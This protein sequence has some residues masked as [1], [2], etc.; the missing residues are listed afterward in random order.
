MQHISIL[1]SNSC[2]THPHQVQRFASIE[3]SLRL[4][5]TSTTIRSRLVSP[6]GSQGGKHSLSA[7]INTSLFLAFT[8]ALLISSTHAQVTCDSGTFLRDDKCIPCAPGTFQFFSIQRRTSCTKCRAGTF[9]NFPGAEHQTDC[10]I[11]AQNYFARPGATSCKPC[12]PGTISGVASGRCFPLCP[13]GSERSTNKCTPCNP[14]FYNDGTLRI[15]K[16]CPS[17]TTTLVKGQSQCT[18]CPPGTHRDVSRTKSYNGLAFKCAPCP[19]ASFSNKAGAVQCSLCPVGTVSKPNRRGCKSCPPGT[20]RRIISKTKCDKCPKGTN[21]KGKKPAGCLHPKRGCP[22]HTYLHPSGDCRGCMPGTRLDV[23]R[24]R[25]VK[26]RKNEVSNGGD[27]K[28]CKVCPNNTVPE[29]NRSIFEA[30]RCTC[31]PGWHPKPLGD[32]RG[33]LCKPCKAGEEVDQYYSTNV[34][35]FYGYFFRSLYFSEAS[36]LGCGR[37]HFTARPGTDKCSACPSGLYNPFYEGTS[38]LKCPKGSRANPTDSTWFPKVGQ[39]ECVDLK[40]SCPFGSERLDN[41]IC[42]RK[43]CPGHLFPRGRT[44][45]SCDSGSRYDPAIGN[46]V[47]CKW[48]ERSASGLSSHNN[49]KCKACGK[50]GQFAGADCFCGNFK[51]LIGKKCKSCPLGLVGYDNECVKCP[52]TMISIRTKNGLASCSE[53][54]GRTYKANRKH[55]KCTDCPA[56]HVRARDFFNDIMYGC[57]PKGMYPIL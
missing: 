12:P 22:F 15:C 13:P 2:I 30:A 23:A 48:N 49:T 14:A 31:R 55:T 51:A 29:P 5:I 10:H 20:F 50:A 25:C 57:M 39:A 42:V 45:W 24:N 7:M 17:G 28:K 8:S 44:C 1:G 46:C 33:E 27:D 40:N 6:F 53:C 43:S 32:P 56:N 37:G 41:G 21:S 11:C 38:C 36:C 54:K 52:S 4:L 34:R 3:G 16:A 35:A 18:A 19:A 26:C 9:N 47:R